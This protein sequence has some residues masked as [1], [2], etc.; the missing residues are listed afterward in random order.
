MSTPNPMNADRMVVIAAVSEMTIDL[1]AMA[2]TMN[3]T[4]MM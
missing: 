1:K 4:P 3:V 2:S